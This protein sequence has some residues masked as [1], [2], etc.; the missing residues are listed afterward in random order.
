MMATIMDKNSLPPDYTKVLNEYASNGFRVLAIGSKIIPGN[1]YKS[2]TREQAE[3][4]LIFNG[5]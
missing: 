2:I 5:F 1:D 3:T 4:D